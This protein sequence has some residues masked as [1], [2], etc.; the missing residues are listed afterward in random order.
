VRDAFLDQGAQA[1]EDTSAVERV[2]TALLEQD[3]V[4]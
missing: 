4:L 2:T 3:E 1:I